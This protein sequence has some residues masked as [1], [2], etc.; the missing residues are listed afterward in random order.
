MVQQIIIGIILIVYIIWSLNKNK[1]VNK[2]DN[3]R[4]CCN[5]DKRD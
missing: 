2:H 1:L 5:C 3:K 4:K